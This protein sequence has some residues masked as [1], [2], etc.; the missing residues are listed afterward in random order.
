MY[1][2][3][4]SPRESRGCTDSVPPL[5][6]AM[7]RKAQAVVL[8]FTLGV[9]QACYAYVPLS[10]SPLPGTQVA[11]DLTDRGRA[12]MAT[13]VGAWP[14]TVEGA[15]TAQSDSAYMLSVTSVRNQR[16]GVSKWSGEALTVRKDL[17]ARTRERHFSTTRTAMAAGLSVG[18][19][20][21]FALTRG[22]FGGGSENSPPPPPPCC[23]Q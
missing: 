19:I 5:T 3:L 21:F 13:L 20:L 11:I 16:G 10:D 1:N 2:V 8:A 17:V 14:E 22:L 15:L 23:E 4:E 18:A 6:R 9:S 12:E 7:S